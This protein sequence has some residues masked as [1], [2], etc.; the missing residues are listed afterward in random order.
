L[1]LLLDT[2]VWLWSVERADRLPQPVRREIG[3]QRNEIYL[4]P[5]SIWEAYSVVQRGRI[6]LDTSFSEWLTHVLS[7]APLREAPFN[8]AVAREI[9]RIR[10]PHGDPGDVFLVATASVFDLTLVTADEQLLGLKWLKTM[11]CL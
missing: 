8:F 11:P 7:Q 10:L 5:V 2:H 1:K 6:R 9:T 4:S 3:S